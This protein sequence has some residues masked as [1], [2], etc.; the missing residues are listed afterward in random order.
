MSAP[1]WD[2]PRW[3]RVT[4]L[5]AQALELAP[6]QRTRFLSELDS[7]DPESAPAVA[8]MLQ[9][10]AA[11]V[12]DTP[13][14]ATSMLGAAVD[15]VLP[16]GTRLGAYA[17]ESCLGTGGMGRVYRAQRVDGEVAQTVAIKCLR[18]RERDPAFMRRFLRERRILARLTHPLIARF[19]D[20]GTDAGG[21]PFVVIEYI[22]GIAITEYVRNKRLSLRAR[23]QLLI[24][25]MS[26]V[27]YSHRQ[28]IV[29]RDLKP[30]NVLVDANGDPHLLDFGIAKPLA[31]FAGMVEADSETAVEQRAFSLAHAAPE[32]LR[33][34]P[35]GTACD[36]YALGVLAYE[37]LSGESPLDLVG[38]SFADAERK[39]LDEFPPAPSARLAQG[40]APDGTDGNAW[41]RALRGDLDNI[42]LHALKKEPEQRFATVDAFIA[43]LERHLDNQPI[44]LRGR[45]Q[46]YRLQ[47]FVRRHRLA[48]GLSLTLLLALTIG[49]VG[50]WRQNLAIA[51]E[52]DLAHSQQQRAQ[53]LND[54]LLSAFEAADPSRNQGEEVSAR[55]VLD[56]AARRVERAQLDPGTRAS[57]LTAVADVYR[58]LGL[59]SESAAAARSASRADATLPALVSVRAWRALS[60]ASL[61]S[62]EIAAAQTALDH[63]RTAKLDPAVPE[64]RA[65]EIE[66]ELVAI[67]ILVAQ[68]RAPEALD[69]QATLYARARS[70]V[71]PADPLV[72]RCGMAY[73]ER[74]RIMKRPAESVALIEVLLS[75][76][77]HPARDP[78]GVR[79]L[80]A[81]A[82][83]ERDLGQFDRAAVHAREYADAVRVLYGEPH[84]ANVSALDLL[85]KTERDHGRL[86]AAI[87][88]QR[89]MLELSPPVSSQRAAIL[90]VLADTLL[91][92]GQ[93]DEALRSATAAVAM[94]GETLP[95]GNANLAHFWITLAEI[96][97][98]RGDY[99]TALTELDE[100]ER[101]FA[102]SA[103]GGAPGWVRALGHVLRGEALL[104]LGKRSDSE[105]A[106]ERGWQKL[107]TLDPAHP[108][109][110]RG[111]RL[112]QA[113]AAVVAPA[114]G[115]S[116]PP[117]ST[118]P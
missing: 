92:A 98:A 66:L 26:A 8:R 101:V 29:H 27:A 86:D 114:T 96:D 35:V 38:L 104:A 72:V 84:R 97:L 18:F 52:R 55:A 11:F 47:R 74:L 41:R 12:T 110:Q 31:P 67:E 53:A 61:G 40:G 36:V 39:I 117:G 91:Q 57:L 99:A 95:A 83:A 78:I 63:A 9:A 13:P 16:A 70:D 42:V 116:S 37:L 65:E 112:R 20:T 60:R 1:V 15:P 25:V 43:D 87:V 24:K 111:L 88:A 21:Q 94:A 14:S 90:N 45:Q 109:F 2:R 93:L 107:G 73:A 64:E 59:M 80:G 28:L 62:G 108:F 54:L 106:L 89:Q 17:I 44:S 33:G 69:R 75:T 105:S 3:E 34:D 48:V 102:A 49:S 79:L 51:S 19:L 6:D 100:S 56:Q 82:R 81:R 103:S 113:L 118:K 76:I 58:T 115:S 32:Q 77:A 46:I 7:T 10:D 50:L 85:A 22:D 68:G 4:A 23:L 5:F 71:E 30:A